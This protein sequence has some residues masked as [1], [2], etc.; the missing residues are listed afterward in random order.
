MLGH[1]GW[2]DI[3]L[4]T[5]IYIHLPYIVKLGSKLG[6]SENKET[7]QE[8]KKNVVWTWQERL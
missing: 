5:Y 4:R 3:H 7:I 6:T 2:T 1:H 8:S